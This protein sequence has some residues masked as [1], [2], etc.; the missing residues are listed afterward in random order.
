MKKPIKKNSDELVK[1]FGEGDFRIHMFSMDLRFW[2]P[3]FRF[4][5]FVGL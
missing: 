3:D 4:W 5:N 1:K 2:S